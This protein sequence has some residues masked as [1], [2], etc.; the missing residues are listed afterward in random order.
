MMPVSILGTSSA[1]SA[2]PLSAA[3]AASLLIRF[4]LGE[5]DWFLCYYSKH[6]Q[7]KG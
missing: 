6:E 1:S 3:N 5:E 2:Q 7:E 4:S